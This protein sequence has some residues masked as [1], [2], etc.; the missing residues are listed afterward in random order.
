MDF[1]D[2]VLCYGIATGM[3]FASLLIL[4]ALYLLKD[5]DSVQIK[6]ERE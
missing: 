6:K 2:K 5:V 1:I 3:V 4:L